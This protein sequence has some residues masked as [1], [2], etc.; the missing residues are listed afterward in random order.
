MV[1]RGGQATEDARRT[2]PRGRVT[3]DLDIDGAGL[4]F[5][6]GESPQKIWIGGAQE[7]D[8]SKSNVD[9]QGRP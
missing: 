9:S 5:P 8:E 6:R 3:N 7:R 4:G 1:R 2:P